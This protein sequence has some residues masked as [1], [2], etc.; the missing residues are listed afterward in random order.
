MTGGRVCTNRNSLN[1]KNEIRRHAISKITRIDILPNN[2]RC[3]TNILRGC[4]R[5]GV[6]TPRALP[7]ISKRASTPRLTEYYTGARMSFITQRLFDV[8]VPRYYSGRSFAFSRVYTLVVRGSTF[9]RVRAY[10]IRARQTASFRLIFI[11]VII[12][13]NLATVLRRRFPRVAHTQYTAT[14]PPPTP[15]I[16]FSRNIIAVTLD[17]R[18]GVA[19]ESFRISFHYVFRNNVWNARR[20]VEGF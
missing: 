13:S 15:T 2:L 12:S 19:G 3:W 6:Q 8:K 20:L 11:I 5:T 9:T 1:R 14:P 17:G 18:G 7:V 4:G 16:L 10:V